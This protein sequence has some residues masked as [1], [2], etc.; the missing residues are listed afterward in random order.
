M[1]LRYGFILALLFSTATFAETSDVVLQG[2]SFYLKRDELQNFLQTAYGSEVSDIKIIK[3]FQTYAGVF[4]FEFSTYFR[5]VIFKTSKHGIN[6]EIS[7]LLHVNANEN[8][9]RAN[10][11][12]AVPA[13]KVDP[14]PKR[15]LSDYT[16]I[17][18][19]DVK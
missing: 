6:Y 17:H 9:I 1:Y 18:T 19:F 14:T 13:A 7:C 2:P 4:F 11:C 10:K 8:F 12:S 5:R 16:T 3:V 15:K